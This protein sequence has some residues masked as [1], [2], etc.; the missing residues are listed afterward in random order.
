MLHIDYFKTSH[1]L[2]HPQ[3][4]LSLSVFQYRTIYI[5]LFIEICKQTFISLLYW[6]CCLHT[7]YS[8]FH[9]QFNHFGHISAWLQSSNLL[10][11]YIKIIN[12]LH[13]QI[14]HFLFL[15]F[16]NISL[17]VNSVINS[18]H[19]LFSYT[20][21]FILPPL[22][23]LLLRSFPFFPPLPY[24]QMLDFLL[25]VFIVSTIFP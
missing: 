15:I 17:I 21:R 9:I 2:N 11:S 19:E 20:P 16:L 3:L 7:L 8:N 4:F 5:M 6:K 13:F 22:W 10:K 18:F 1:S 23:L 14:K 24:I 25:A 12:H